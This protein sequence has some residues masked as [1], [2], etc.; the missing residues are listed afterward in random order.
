MKVHDAVKKVLDASMMVVTAYLSDLTDAE[1]LSRPVPSANHPA[2]QLG[3]LIVA[4]FQMMEGIVPGK[5]PKLPSGF[6]EAHAK[7][8]ASSNDPKLFL[9]KKSYLDLYQA[10]RTATLQILSGLSETDLDKPGPEAF[11][12]WAPTYGALLIG[13]GTHLMMHVGQFA[14]LR[15]VLGKPVVI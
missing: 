7:E 4:E 14:V 11:R 3:H 15:R 5:S 1:L 12:S 2:W 10:Q 8:T 13:T 9:S 6:I